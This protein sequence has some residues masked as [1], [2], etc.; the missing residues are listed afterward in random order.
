MVRCSCLVLALVVGAVS[1]LVVAP[2][3][4]VS[5]SARVAAGPVMACNGGKGGNG[6][7]NPPKDKTVYRPKLSKLIQRADSA[8]NVK[9][10][11]RRQPT[12]SSSRRR[13][14][15]LCQALCP[16]RLC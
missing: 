8:E 14:S 15:P 2:P 4:A 12:R 1:A 10:Q 16:S 7:K 9:A 5:S 13:R 6:G 11:P 3:A